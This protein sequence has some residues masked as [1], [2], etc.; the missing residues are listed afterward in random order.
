MLTYLPICLSV[1][2]SVCLSFSRVCIILG[3]DRRC[4]KLFV[5]LLWVCFLI[6]EAFDLIDYNIVLGKLQKIYDHTCSLTGSQT[7]YQ[8]EYRERQ[9]LNSVS[10]MFFSLNKYYK[11]YRPLLK[12]AS[13]GRHKWYRLQWKSYEFLFSTVKFRKYRLS[14]PSILARL[15]WG[16]EGS[17]YYFWGVVT[18]GTSLLLWGGG[19]F[20]TFGRSLLSS[21]LGIFTFGFQ[22][23]FVNV[24]KCTVLSFQWS[25]GWST[26]YYVQQ[27]CNRVWM[28]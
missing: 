3:G 16:G 27:S 23:L 18:F 13:T 7:S 22:N 5:F 10:F 19:A 6:F 25:F 12:M 9:Q 8:K 28:K 4:R 2:L 1:C 14:L 24:K 11:W 20:V 21:L 17:R 15:D 26:L